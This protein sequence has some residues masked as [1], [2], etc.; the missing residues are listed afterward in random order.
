MDVN[1]YHRSEYEKIELVS[2]IAFSIILVGCAEHEL[3]EKER[4]LNAR[5]AMSLG[6][7]LN[8]GA[9]SRDF[10]ESAKLLRES[11]A[12]SEEIKFRKI[13]RKKIIRSN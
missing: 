2:I 1:W 10:A 8:P 4:S 3:C 6:K 7:A 12:I 9:T 5:S 13:S 11:V